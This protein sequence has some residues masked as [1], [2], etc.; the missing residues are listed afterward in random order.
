MLQMINSQIIIKD[1]RTRITHQMQRV[2]SIK[3][4]GIRTDKYLKLVFSNK[5]YRSEAY[6]TKLRSLKQYSFHNKLEQYNYA[7]ME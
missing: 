6:Y 5:N 3:Y 2:N 7:L 4:L 1:T